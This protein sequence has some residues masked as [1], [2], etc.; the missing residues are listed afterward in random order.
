MS[1]LPGVVEKYG[2]EI[3]I[4][5][6]PATAAQEVA[7]RLVRAGV[8]AI[9][10]LAFTHIK[11]PREV[12][13]VDARIVASLQELAYAVTIGKKMAAKTGQPVETS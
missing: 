7:D 4:I 6:V 9:L 2:I 13:V 5:A 3:G 8:T 10:N 12:T 1:A 11:A